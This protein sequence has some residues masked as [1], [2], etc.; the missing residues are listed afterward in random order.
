MIAKMRTIPQLVKEAKEQDPQTP[1]NAHFVRKLVKRG[2]IKAIIVNR[3]ILISVEAF[4]RYMNNGKETQGENAEG[5]I[6]KITE[7]PN[8]I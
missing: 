5:K 6:R 4:N 8:E 3:K 1:L 2:D 7:Y